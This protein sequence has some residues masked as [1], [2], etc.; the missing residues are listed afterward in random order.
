[1]AEQLASDKVQITKIAKRMIAEHNNYT[2]DEE[3]DENPLLKSASIEGTRP[4]ENDIN[5]ILKEC[6]D[7][8]KRFM[9]RSVK[10]KP[11]S[12]KF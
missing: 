12:H 2:E 11:K 9:V 3:V 4:V 8:E 5:W 7:Y 1:M 10:I 6:G